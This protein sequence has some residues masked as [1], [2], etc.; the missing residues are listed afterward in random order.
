MQ[1]VKTDVNEC[2]PGFPKMKMLRLGV[3]GSSFS[4][5][6][7]LFSSV[8]SLILSDFITVNFCKSFGSFELVGDT[9]NGLNC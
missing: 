9:L 6:G 5:Q 3:L 7:L 2:Q 8:I 4:E 1:N